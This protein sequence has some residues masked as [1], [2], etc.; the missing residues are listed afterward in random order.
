M[1]A[2]HQAGLGIHVLGSQQKMCKCRKSRAGPGLS[3][4]D[5]QPLRD[6]EGAVSQVWHGQFM[7]PCLWKNL[8]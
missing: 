8:I 6:E 5:T 3:R 4:Q 1:Q 2:G 7:V